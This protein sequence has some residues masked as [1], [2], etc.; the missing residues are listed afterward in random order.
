MLVTASKKSE[1]PLEVKASGPQNGP[2]H[3]SLRDLALGAFAGWRQLHFLFLKMQT[4]NPGTLKESLYAIQ[5]TR[6]P[7]ERQ[8]NE[9]GA[10]RGGKIRAWKLRERPLGLGPWKPPGKM[11]GWPRANLQAKT[12]KTVARFFLIRA[13]FSRRE[14]EHTRPRGICV[15]AREKV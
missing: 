12:R 7:R 5:L 11:T 15:V 3:W 4:M 9:I 1:S 10:F 13:S 2:T 8:M 14:L 6:V